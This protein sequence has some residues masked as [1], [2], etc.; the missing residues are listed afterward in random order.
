M[1]YQLDQLEPSLIL[2]SRS[3]YVKKE[4]NKIVLRGD[5]VFHKPLP[6]IF[7]DPILSIKSRCKKFFQ[8]DPLTCTL[9]Y[10]FRIS[11]N[12][13]KKEK[14]SVILV[15]IKACLRSSLPELVSEELSHKLGR[16]KSLIEKELREGKG[17]ELPKDWVDHFLRKM[18]DQIQ[19]EG[20]LT[21][22]ES[23]QGF[24]FDIPQD[25]FFRLKRS[26]WRNVKT[27]CL[28]L[29]RIDIFF[30][31]MLRLTSHSNSKV[32]YEISEFWKEID[33]IS[34]DLLR[35]VS[36][37]FT[38]L[39]KG[40]VEYHVQLFKNNLNLTLE[41]EWRKQEVFLDCKL[42]VE[43][44]AS[45]ISS[46]LGNVWVSKVK[47][48]SKDHLPTNCLREWVESHC[49]FSTRLLTPI[50]EVIELLKSILMKDL[51]WLG[52][53][54]FKILKNLSKQDKLEISYEIIKVLNLLELKLPNKEALK[55]L[56]NYSLKLEHKLSPLKPL[57]TGERRERNVE[58]GRLKDDL[59]RQE[60]DERWRKALLLYSRL[61]FE[62]KEKLHENLRTRFDIEAKENSTLYFSLKSK[63]ELAWKND[64]LC[65]M[66]VYN[67]EN[68]YGK[69]YLKKGWFIELKDS[70][71]VFNC[72]DLWFQVALVDFYWD[73]ERLKGQVDVSDEL[74]GQDVTVNLNK[75]KDDFF[76]YLKKKYQCNLEEVL[77]FITKIKGDL[78][79]QELPIIP[80]SLLKFL[81][82]IKMEVNSILYKDDD[83]NI[84][85]EEIV[86]YVEDERIVIAK[87]YLTE[88]TKRFLVKVLFFTNN[89]HKLNVNSKVIKIP[90]VLLVERLLWYYEFK[91]M[92]LVLI[93][94]ITYRLIPEFYSSIANQFWE[95][96]F[97]KS[98]LT[99]KELREIV[100]SIA[101]NKSETVQ[102]NSFKNLI[103]KCKEYIVIEDKS[104][105]ALEEINKF[106]E[107]FEE[108][109]Q[110]NQSKKELFLPLLGDLRISK[111]IK[112]DESPK[113]KQDRSKK[114]LIHLEKTNPDSL[115][116]NITVS[117]GE[118]F[119]S[120]PF[121][122]T[123]VHRVKKVRKMFSGKV[124]ANLAV[125]SAWY[126]NFFL[127]SVQLFMIIILMFVLII[128]LYNQDRYREGLSFFSP[129]NYL[130]Y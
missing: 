2:P 55:L 120:I 86:N 112:K 68:L 37:K 57:L 60:F 9:Y 110:L 99:V 20:D 72:I 39:N 40:K 128:Q 46:N 73:D 6:D 71:N 79:V 51:G 61:D 108:S 88:N 107:P 122:K 16:D 52:E 30:L 124:H 69:V 63:S 117:I 59:I 102:V 67:F 82:N 22:L 65:C 123:V 121:Y 66:V 77:E 49:N 58:R 43:F 126:Y 75:L 115:L 8:G 38:Q 19:I 3:Y 18:M 23:S 78:N 21:P 90:V 26:T 113:N 42:F 106:L 87:R 80:S 27:N 41:D 119:T 15:P 104:E 91:P 81:E 109:D 84:N 70:R 111:A 35:N 85:N 7:H 47:V 127:F 11:D 118:F 89:F 12:L 13:N 103:K 5:I 36:I 94:L 125:N 130:I 98:S 76:N 33:V 116:T 64:N 32:I 74:E 45:S 101:E 10:E 17:L 97:E 83:C 114:F 14:K 129:P 95:F 100:K 92:S 50:D 29:N 28:G 96:L 44:D 4:S 25:E 62:E 93:G 34:D 53:L 48:Q 54:T 56:P 24:Q 1:V 31:K 105:A